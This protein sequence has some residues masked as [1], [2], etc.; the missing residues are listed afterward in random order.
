[1]DSRVKILGG[2]LIL[3]LIYIIFLKGCGDKHTCLKTEIIEVDTVRNE[4]TIDTIVIVNT[5][6]VYKYISV[7]VPVPY[8]D[9][10]YVSKA[11][12]NFD[13]FIV[14]QPWIYED[15]IRD[16]TMS[17]NYWIR[18]W[19]YI[20][21]ISVGYRPLARYYIEEK[22]VLELEVT[23]RKRFQGFYFGMDIGVGKD[24]LRHVAPMLELSTAKTNY[25]AGFDFNDKAVIIGARFKIGK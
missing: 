8:L 9:T 6:T 24:G 10:I 21:S 2:T 18:S 22:S 19:G 11:V 12:D 5:D 13:D 20:D 17:I 15:T 4:I 1:M 16:D 7:K 23:K 25:N 3:A 14:E